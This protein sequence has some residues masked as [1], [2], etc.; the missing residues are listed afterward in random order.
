MKNVNLNLKKLVPKNFEFILDIEGNRR[1][2]W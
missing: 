1:I 2:M